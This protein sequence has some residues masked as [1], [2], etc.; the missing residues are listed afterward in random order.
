MLL[1]LIRPIMVKP[2][3]IV[4]AREIAKGSFGTIYSAMFNDMK[5]AVK[6]INQVIIFF[7][8]ITGC[9]RH[10]LVTCMEF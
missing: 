6:R 5:V 8:C 3:K 9:E 1:D 2:S 10:V 4:G 7:T